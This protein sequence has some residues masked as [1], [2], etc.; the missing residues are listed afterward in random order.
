MAKVTNKE[1]GKAV[2]RKFG[3]NDDVDYVNFY[4]NGDFV[5]L[6]M[7]SVEEI[8]HK[9]INSV[10]NQYRELGDWT[11]IK[12][13]AITHEI[14]IPY[15]G[16]CGFIHAHEQHSYYRTPKASAFAVMGF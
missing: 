13:K 11:L 9:Q 15:G 12:T 7:V 1:F 6:D 14:E 8:T 10:L 3:R 2:K 4:A 16:G 5:V